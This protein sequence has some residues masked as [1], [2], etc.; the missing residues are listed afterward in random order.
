LRLSILLLMTILV[1]VTR[2]YWA[3]RVASSLVCTSETPHSDALLLEN[4]D[5]DYLVFERAETLVRAGV[6]SRVIVHVHASGEDGEPNGVDRGIVELFAKI[7]RLPQFEIVPIRQTE[8]ISFNAAVQ[9]RDALLEK[10]VRSV[11]VIAPGFRSR[12][13]ALVYRQVLTPAGIRVAC[14]PV[15]GVY[16]PANWTETWHGIQGVIEH[17]TKLQY[18]RFWVLPWNGS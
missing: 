3:P 7:A 4:F 11:V 5:P 12:R 17:F 14:D 15:F 8:P 10:Q 9:I 16:T 6:A 2:R 18:Y 1:P 13:S